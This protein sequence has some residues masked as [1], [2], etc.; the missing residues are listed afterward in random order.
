M[1]S[2]AKERGV[3]LASVLDKSEAAVERGAVPDRATCDLIVDY[4]VSRVYV[5]V[6]T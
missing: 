5:L 6:D 1:S 4:Y 3:L 2:D